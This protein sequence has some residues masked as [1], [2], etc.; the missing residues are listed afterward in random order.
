MTPRVFLYRGGEQRQTRMRCIKCGGRFAGKQDMR[1][2]L[3]V[4]CRY[5]VDRAGR[6]KR[7]EAA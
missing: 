7:K 1:R 2:K 4:A 5:V 3:C 6:R